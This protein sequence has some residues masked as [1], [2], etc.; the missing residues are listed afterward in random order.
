MK[1]DSTDKKLRKSDG[2]FLLL[3]FL[4]SVVSIV[5]GCIC[6]G[7]IKGITQQNRLVFSVLFSLIVLIV[8]TF[9]VTA[10]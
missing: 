2:I 3:F 7:G 4:F 10:S 5:L 6:I 1:K 9:S 8:C